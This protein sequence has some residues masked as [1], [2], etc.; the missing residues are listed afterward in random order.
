MLFFPAGASKP[1]RVQGAYISEA[2]VEK[3]V[4][5]VKQQRRPSYEKNFRF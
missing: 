1:K 3:L 5:F 4:D 2:E